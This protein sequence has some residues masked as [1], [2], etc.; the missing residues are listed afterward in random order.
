MVTLCLYVYTLYF[1][2]KHKSTQP[3]RIRAPSSVQPRHE[4]GIFTRETSQQNCNKRPY[5]TKNIPEDFNDV[6]T[7]RNGNA[8]FFIMD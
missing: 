8:A 7:E 3:E 6:F 4:K 2:N 1:I 5:K